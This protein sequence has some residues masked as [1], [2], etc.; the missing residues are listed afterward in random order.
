[1]SDLLAGAVGD[2]DMSIFIREL[3]ELEIASP[4]ID[5]SSPSIV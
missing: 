2:L 1:M 4:V 5:P 3:S